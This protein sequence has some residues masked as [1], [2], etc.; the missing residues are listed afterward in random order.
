MKTNDLFDGTLTRPYDSWSDPKMS[1]ETVKIS[2]SLKLNPLFPVTSPTNE[3]FTDAVGAFVLSLA[4]AGSKDV[5][6]I[7]AKNAR[8]NELIALCVQL[9]YSVSNIANGDVEALVSTSMPLRKKR[10]SSVVV[11]PSNLRIANG[12]N[13]G[14][15]DLRVDTMKGA[16]SF[17]FRYTEYPPT[18]ASVWAET[19]C[20]RS[21]PESSYA[22]RRCIGCTFYYFYYNSLP[23][24]GSKYV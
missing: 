13:P 9:G 24:Y 21:R 10:Q 15:L 2:N 5:N 20:K 16:V 4:K 1:V 22:K 11:P 6:A 3:V 12:M 17:K 8:R 7:A 19:V 23:G 14:E 18:E